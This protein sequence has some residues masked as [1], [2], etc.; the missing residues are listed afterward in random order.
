MGRKRSKKH[1]ADPELFINPSGQLELIDKSAEQQ[2]MGGRAVE[3]LGMSFES[4]EARREYFLQQ[5]REGLEELQEELGGVPFTT[6]EDAVARM[7]SVTQWPMG[8][9]WRLRELAQQMT[10]THRSTRNQG[11]EN[12][13][14]LQLW[15]DG[16]GF[17]HGEV[18]DI[19]RLSD[20]PYYTACPNPFLED[21]IKHYGKPYDP[22]VSYSKE[23]FT[24]DVSEGKTDPIYTAHSYHTKVPHKAIMRAILHYTEPGDIVLDGFAFRHDGRGSADVQ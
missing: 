14:L 16:I 7:K 15:K 17:P 13:D 10:K 24:V 5:L 12:K 19:L 2:V 1:T 22:S 11:P 20:P 8:D 3:C 18:E 4:D 9:E 23:P 6:V 21:F